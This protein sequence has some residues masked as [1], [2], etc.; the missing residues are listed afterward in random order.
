M[1][2]MKEVNRD[3]KTTFIFSTHDAKI[4]NLTDHRIKILDGSVIEDIKNTSR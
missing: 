1:E 3:L 4:V 2:L